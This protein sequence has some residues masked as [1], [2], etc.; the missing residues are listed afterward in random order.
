MFITCFCHE[1]AVPL[2]NVYSAIKLLWLF[3]QLDT[4]KQRVCPA[5]FDLTQKLTVSG[6]AFAVP[7]LEKQSSVF[8]SR[9]QTDSIS[10]ISKH[11]HRLKH[12]TKKQNIRKP[13]RPHTKRV[14]PNIGVQRYETWNSRVSNGKYTNTSSIDVKLVTPLYISICQWCKN[15]LNKKQL[16]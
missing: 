1:F 7:H 9:R 8:S 6:F 11:S 10:C 4:L 3:G 12:N 14:Y 16:Y 5:T 2:G 15:E 13:Q